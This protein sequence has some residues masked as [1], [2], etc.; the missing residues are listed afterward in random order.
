MALSEA[1]R[2]TVYLKSLELEIIGSCNKITLHCDS[3]SALKLATNHVSHKRSKHI[4]LRYHYIR[5][6]IVNDI[7]ETKYLPTADILTKGLCGVK[8]YK[9]ME[10]LGIVKN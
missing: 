9:F 5:E 1:G 8:H 4:D 7:I 6:I 2:E 3:Q 10:K